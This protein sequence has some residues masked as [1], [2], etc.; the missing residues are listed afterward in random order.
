LAALGASRPGRTLREASVTRHIA[1]TTADVELDAAV[2]ARRNRRL[3]A[4]VCFL[5]IPLHRILALAHGTLNPVAYD[6][7]SPSVEGNWL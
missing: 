3:V 2:V 7:N 4:A 1:G 6:P 5:V